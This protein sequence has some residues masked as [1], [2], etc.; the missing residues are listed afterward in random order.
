MNKKVVENEIVNVLKQYGSK[1]QSLRKQKTMSIAVLAEKCG[2]TEE[3]LTM[4][5]NGT[6][7]D[8]DV[9]TIKGIS[10]FGYT[11]APDG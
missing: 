5:E 6:W 4:T 9:I 10:G 1:V 3:Q 8:L 2:L 7:E 11:P